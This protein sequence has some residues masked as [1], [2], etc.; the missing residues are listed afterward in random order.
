MAVTSVHVTASGSVSS[1][2]CK[3]L[4]VRGL[5]GAGVGTVTLNDGGSGGTS[6]H[7][8]DSPNAGAFGGPIPG[9]G[10]LFATDC[11]AT[12][13]GTAAPAAVTVI[14]EDYT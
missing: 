9:G 4:A 8:E 7:I 11:Y 3:V 2:P 1:T 13:G 14:I 10:L 12:L 5:G 6:K